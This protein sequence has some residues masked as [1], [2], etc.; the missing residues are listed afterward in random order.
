MLVLGAGGG[1]EIL[2]ARHL[3]ARRIDAVELNPQVV[4]LL[5]REFARLHGRLLDEP[6]VELAVGDARGMLASH[7]RRYDLIQLSL[8]GGAAGGL[9]GLSEDYLHTVEAF[10]LY[11]SRLTP[12]GFLSITR[13]VQV[14]PRDGLKL[15]RHR[16]RGAGSVPASPTPGAGCS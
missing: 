15:A 9:G 11:L 5:R 6:G 10:E 14:P 2:R 3:G 1:L 8:A 13:H 16:D 12:G 7:E 4:H